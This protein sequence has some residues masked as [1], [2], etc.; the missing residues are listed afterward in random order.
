MFGYGSQHGR[1]CLPTQSVRLPATQNKI[2]TQLK[3]LYVIK[4]QVKSESS[5]YYLRFDI[6]L[7]ILKTYNNLS[8]PI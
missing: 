7:L 5:Y 8:G 2:K 1:G 4:I 3:N 6:L